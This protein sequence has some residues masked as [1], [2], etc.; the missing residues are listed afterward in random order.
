MCACMLFLCVLVCNISSAQ[1]LQK[2]VE[3]FFR[4]TAHLGHAHT[5]GKQLTIYYF[6]VITDL[7]Q[8]QKTVLSTSCYVTG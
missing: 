3:D 1:T 7:Q 4:A 8:K 6:L 5:G 2:S